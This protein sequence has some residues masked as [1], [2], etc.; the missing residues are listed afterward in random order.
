MG[1]VSMARYLGGQYVVG[2]L[3]SGKGIYWQAMR[4]L[5]SVMAHTSQRLRTNGKPFEGRIARFS[6][7]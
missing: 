2:L 6:G 3:V 4:V 5:A 7:S 1:V